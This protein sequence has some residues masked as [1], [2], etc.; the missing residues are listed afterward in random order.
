MSSAVCRPGPIRADDQP[1]GIGS[2]E[3]DRGVQRLGLAQS[4]QG[5]SAWPCQRPSTFQVDWAWRRSR[6][7]AGTAAGWPWG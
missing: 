7:T 4:G 5:G 3:P 6:T 1:E 2:L